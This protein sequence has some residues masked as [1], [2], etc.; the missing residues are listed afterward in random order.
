MKETTINSPEF[1]SWFNG[2]VD[3]SKKYIAEH[4]TSLAPENFRSDDGRRYIRVWRGNS[5]YAF[6]DKTNGDVLKADSWKKP[7][8]HAR[9]NIHNPDN[10]LTC[11]GPYG[12]VY[13]RGGG[14]I[15]W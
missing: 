6:I 7:A 14:N 15:G 12:I 2:V 5:V 4:F 3:L 1:L 13:L 8:K 11:T 9:G 10:G